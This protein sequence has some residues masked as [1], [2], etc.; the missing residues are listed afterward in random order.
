MQK[1]LTLISVYIVLKCIFIELRRYETKQ[2]VKAGIYKGG[3]IALAV[4]LKSYVLN[5]A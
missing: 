3:S 4:R 2:I 1:L 5:I